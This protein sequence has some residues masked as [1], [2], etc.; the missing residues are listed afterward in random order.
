MR[1]SVLRPWGVAA[2]Y[3]L[4]HLGI[5]G[6]SGS[7]EDSED[8]EA[9]EENS[10][11]GASNDEGNA[12]EA[13]S[14]APADGAGEGNA[15]ATETANA[16]GSE[17]GNSTDSDLQ[18]IISDVSG[19]EG[20]GAATNTPPVENAPPPVQN[21]QAAPANP[22]PAPAAA[23]AAPVATAG[24]GLPEMGSKMPYIVEPGDTL[25]KIA[26]KIYGN[27][28]RWHDIQELSNLAN[29]HRIYPGDVVYYQLSDD[30]VSFA[31]TYESAPRSE[32]TASGNDTLASIAAKV[33]G[34]NINW[35]VIWRENGHI[36]TPDKL[37]AGTI[38]YYVNRGGAA[39]AQVEVKSVTIVAQTESQTE[40]VTAETVLY[41]VVEGDSQVSADE[42]DTG[43]IFTG[44][45]MAFGSLT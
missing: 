9:S 18:E 43:I 37:N 39:A 33:T 34:K 25:A 10:Q 45:L 19:Q 13:A 5:A 16:A 12:A 40:E 7:Q 30:A 28:D 22:A 3:L 26:Q 15:A 41:D 8:P 21:A 42:G 29:P 23:P 2:L 31:N 1:L 27:R 17:G 6:C 24:K 44:L 20:Q 38:V 35:R 4:V 36:D 11:E 32:V 14:N